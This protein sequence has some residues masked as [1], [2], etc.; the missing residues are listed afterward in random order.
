MIK[1]DV[2]TAVA[3]DYV[4]RKLKQLEDPVDLLKRFGTYLVNSTKA[5]FT[6]QVG[7]DGKR[8][9][10]SI[11]AREQG[12]QTLRDKGNLY[13]SISYNIIGKDVEWGSNLTYAIT[14]Q[15]GRT[16]KAKNAPYLAFMIGNRFVKKKEVTVPAR[17][18]LGVNS[19]DATELENITRRFLQR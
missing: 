11:R 13:N 1:M 16:I 10:P 18:F 19:K 14:H 15:E 8:W 2:D 17:P 7:P 6:S 5:R 3:L 12:G 4:Q 9:R